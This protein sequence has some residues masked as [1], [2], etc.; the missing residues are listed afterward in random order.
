MNKFTTAQ[1]I[2]SCR[3]FD[4]AVAAHPRIHISRV[5]VKRAPLDL[6]MRYLHQANG[7]AIMQRLS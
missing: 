3:S 5:V 1:L 7:R 2:R 6:Q 4:D